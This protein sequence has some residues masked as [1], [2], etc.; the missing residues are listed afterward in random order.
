[1]LQNI[2]AYFEAYL[3]EICS[4]YAFK[5]KTKVFATRRMEMKNKWCVQVVAKDVS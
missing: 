1:M 4:P 2:N 3:Y 5:C